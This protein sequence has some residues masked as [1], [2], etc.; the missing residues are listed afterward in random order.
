MEVP[1]NSSFDSISPSAKSLLLIKS[2]TTIPFIK[3]AVKL[4]GINKNLHHDNEKFTSYQ[5]ILRSIH[6]ETRYWSID[7]AL[8]AINLNNILEFSSGFSFRGLSKCENSE[9]FYIDT[10]LPQILETKKKMIRELSKK[11]CTYAISNLK[12]L[13]LNVLDKDAFTKVIN[14]FPNG[15]VAIVNEGLLMYL[16][17]EQKKELCSVLHEILQQRGGY[18]ITADVYI[19]RDEQSALSFD[20]F[21]KDGR[22]FLTNHNVEE[23]KFESFKSAKEFFAN[24]GFEL[25]KKVEVSPVKVSSR[26]WLRKV[27]RDILEEL[28]T[29][30]KIRE[31][32]ILKPIKEIKE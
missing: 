25:Y 1:S 20:I 22:D 29:R 13:E 10:D 16:T 15:P 18:W 7:E 9:I 30:T 31:T 14:Q 8:S 23:N 6:F 11:Y 2:L 21:S 28:K 17:K 26:K 5:S 3:E 24:C 4:L 12:L 19:K 27:P 32:W